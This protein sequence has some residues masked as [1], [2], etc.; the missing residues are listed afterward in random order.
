MTAGVIL[1]ALPPAS[2]R[3]TWPERQKTV[4]SGPFD[5]R[6]W[7][8]Y[9]Q[10][11]KDADRVQVFVLGLAAEWPRLTTY[12]PKNV[13]AV[14]CPVTRWTDQGLAAAAQS[15][16]QAVRRSPVDFLAMGMSDPV[17]ETVP[18]ASAI[19]T[20][21]ERPLILAVAA[22]ARDAARLRVTRWEDSG[23]AVGTVW[24]PAVLVM[25]FTPM[26]DRWTRPVPNGGGSTRMIR[27]SPSD[28]DRWWAE[29]LEAINDRASRPWS[30]LASLYH[31]VR[32]PIWV[33]GETQGTP[34][35]LTPVSRQLVAEA[36]RMACSPEASVIVVCEQFPIAEPEEPFLDGADTVMM[37]PRPGIQPF[38]QAALLRQQ[39]ARETPALMLF[40]A[41]LGGQTLAGALVAEFGGDTIR[42]VQPGSTSEST[43]SRVRRAVLEGSEAPG[44]PALVVAPLGTFAIFNG[45]YRRQGRVMSLSAPLPRDEGPAW[46]HH[47]DERAAHYLYGY[48][49]VIAAPAARIGTIRR[50]FKTLG[51]SSPRF[52]ATNQVDFGMK[53]SLCIA[54]GA[55]R[56]VYLSRPHRR[57]STLV[58]I[59][60]DPRAPIM[61]QADI[62]LVGPERLIMDTL[63]A[64]WTEVCAVLG[65]SGSLDEVLR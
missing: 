64:R 15:V 17:D 62:S 29:F 23:Y 10:L 38:R 53:A 57:L 49:V 60:Q 45:C 8:T 54:V 58:A 5:A 30:P 52:H 18:L 50:Q 31:A 48:P 21:L 13:R 28:V 19:A 24:A 42:H 36:R 14:S 35:R 39:W 47:P 34:P 59:H 12:F 51:Q 43:I 2:R 63:H 16:A 9:E 25:K 32:R 46:T 65:Q 11:L 44:A 4:H 26:P 56:A 27:V 55:S 40:P 61:H 6:D 33:W 41:S 1:R 20:L 7:A 3:K 37:L 22:L